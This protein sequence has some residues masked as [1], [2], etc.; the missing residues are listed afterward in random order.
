MGSDSSPNMLYSAALSA[1][2]KLP[3]N[4]SLLL[5]ATEEIFHA[6]SLNLKENTFHEEGAKID[7]HLV[8]EEI[9]M[10]EDPLT[11]V[12]RKKDSSLVQGIR[13]L[14]KKRI[15]AF[16]SCGNTGA[17]LAAS[18]LILP[19]FK[20]VRRPALLA[21]LPTKHSPVSVL[22][23]GGNVSCTSTDLLAFA[24]MGALFV[25]EHF[26]KTNPSVA[27][28]NIGSESKKGTALLRQ[29]H[30]LLSE[31]RLHFQGNIEPRDIYLGKV[32]LVVTDGFSG[33][34]LLK[35]AEGTA[36]LLLEYLNS[37]PIASNELLEQLKKHFSYREYPG[38]LLL[39]V[40]GI[41]VK[42]HGESSEASVIA[43]ILA[44]EK[45]ARSSL[46]EKLQD[47]P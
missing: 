43:G 10:E 3:Q 25:K 16:V 37:S 18:S 20:G 35:T 33:N 23:V 45:F 12:R 9:S 7:F 30:Q 8:S 27:L 31:S 14:K 40:E 46:I 2:K 13:L 6:L 1:A 42:C 28:L 4:S 41:V 26:G 44:A 21:I 29:T 11:S 47:K 24:E 19:H 39:G 17:L 36:S 15:D 38:A 32:D 22:D 34:I 5:L